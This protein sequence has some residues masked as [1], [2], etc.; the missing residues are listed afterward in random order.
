MVSVIIPS[1]EEC[2]SFKRERMLVPSLRA[3]PLLETPDALPQFIRI[4]GTIQRKVQKD[5]AV[6]PYLTDVLHQVLGNNAFGLQIE[7]VTG[8]RGNYP[9]LNTYQCERKFA[10]GPRCEMLHNQYGVGP[11]IMYLLD[12]APFWIL[13][14]ADIERDFTHYL[15]YWWGNSEDYGDK[16]PEKNEKLYPDWIT[17]E[18]MDVPKNMPSRIQWLLRA[19]KENVCEMERPDRWDDDIATWPFAVCSWYGFSPMIT[20]RMARITGENTNFAIGPD[21]R[22]QEVRRRPGD[23]GQSTDP[24]WFILDH[25][26][27][28]VQEFSDCTCMPECHELDTAEAM[29]GSFKPFHELL[30]YL[31]HDQLN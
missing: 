15:H 19:C 9:V 23:M 21:R 28:E 1:N 30:K 17:P 14:P 7:Y 12:N 16:Y 10:I 29:I 25:M 11:L 13:T 5:P 26:I 6:D 24:S 31:S 4:D 3:S 18:N 2:L 27:A 8:Q 20:R 22:M